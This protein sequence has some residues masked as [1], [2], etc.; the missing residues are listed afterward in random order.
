[1]IRA[2]LEA[3]GYATEYAMDGEEALALVV[4][5]PPDLILLDVMMPRLG[6]HEVARRIKADRSL[7]F[8]PI[9]M[10]TALESVES[11]VEGL[12]AG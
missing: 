6:G 4:Q 5:S 7:P 11:K 1:M 10:Q 12:G 2:R 3:K 9:I 8:I